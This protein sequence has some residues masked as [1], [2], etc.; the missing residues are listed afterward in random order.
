[1]KSTWLLIVS[2]FFFLYVAFSQESKLDLVGYQLFKWGMSRKLVESNLRKEKTLMRISEDGEIIVESEIE[3]EGLLIPV[4]IEKH[5]TFFNNALAKVSLLYRSATISNRTDTVF[6]R[7]HTELTGKYGTS[8]KDTSLVDENM[9]MRWA[10]WDFSNGFVVIQS[11]QYPGTSKYKD[12][13][14]PDM[15]SVIYGGNK[16]AEEM[17]LERKKKRE[18]QF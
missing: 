11:L 18:R 8:H 6:S 10:R 15:I 2:S 9:I 5:F 7:F 13:E 4:K 12:L 16:I 14:L 3:F 17:E 1:M